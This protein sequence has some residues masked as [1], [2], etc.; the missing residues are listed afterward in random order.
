[1][2]LRD[3]HRGHRARMKE[4]FLAQGLES[5]QDHNVLELLLFYAVPR[6]DTNPIAHRL[7]DR[8]GSLAAVFDAPIRELEKVEG[9]GKN[10]AVL[11]KLVPQLQRR[12]LTSKIDWDMQDVISSTEDMGAYLLPRFLPE[13]TEVVM[14]VC[15]DAKHKVLNCSR[16]AEGDAACA[17][18]SVRKIVSLAL[19]Y[20]AV[21]AVLAHNHTCGIALPSHDDVAVTLRVRDAL[22][23]VDVELLDHIVVAGDDFVSLYESGLMDEDRGDGEQTE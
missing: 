21:C 8:F 6:A 4:K 7:L 15:M 12:Y 22:A 23:E 13:K 2:D 5:F 14:L 17:P 20:N 11:I 9:V 19:Q 10:A 16:I 1:M 18:V 3:I